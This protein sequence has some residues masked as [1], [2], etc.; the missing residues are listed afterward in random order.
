[1]SCWLAAGQREGGRNG[2]GPAQPWV[3]ERSVGCLFAIRGPHFPLVL[4]PTRTG[5]SIPRR[6]IVVLNTAA[7][8][9]WLPWKT[10]PGA[11]RPPLAGTPLAMGSTPTNG[12]PAGDPSAPPGGFRPVFRL[13]DQVRQRV[14]PEDETHAGRVPAIELGGLREVRVTSR[15][16]PLEPRLLTQRA[17]LVKTRRRPFVRRAAAGAIHQIQRLAG[18]GQRDQQRSLA[19]CRT[20]EKLHSFQFS[21]FRVQGSEFRVQS[22]GFRVRGSGFRVQ[23]KIE[24][25]TR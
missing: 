2:T 1:M 19:G 7:G 12:T 5:T 20:T 22:S 15:K 8:C 23:I 17:G 9:V 4:G 24:Q 16:N 11:T 13:L 14:D 25:F 10:P 3:G 18:V 21:G 6:Q